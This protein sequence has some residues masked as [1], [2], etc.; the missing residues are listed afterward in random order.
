MAIRKTGLNVA[1]MALG[2]F[3]FYMLID[4]LWVHSPLHLAIMAGI[5][6]AVFSSGAVPL[7]NDRWRRWEERKRNGW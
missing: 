7:L 4:R 3:A 5:I 1:W 6:V 2:G